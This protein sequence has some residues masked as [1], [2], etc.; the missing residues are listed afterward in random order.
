MKI[1]A[2]GQ[3]HVLIVGDYRTGT[4]PA[5][6]TKEYIRCL[7]PDAFCLK[8]ASR[9]GRALELIVKIPFASVVLCSGYSAQNIL[10][11]KWA[12]FW[13]KKCVYL[14][15]GS[16]EHENRINHCEDESM[17]RIEAETLRLSDRIYAVSGRFADWLKE[18][19]PEYQEKIGVQRNGVDKSL[20]FSED[21][22]G[23]RGSDGSGPYKRDLNRLLSIGGGMPR[24][25]ILRI[26]EAVELLRK[27]EGLAELKLTVI[28]DQGA[29]SEKIDRYEFVEDLGLVDPKKARELLS[30]AGLFIQNSCFETFGLA[31]M[32]ALVAGCDILVSREVGALELFDTEGLSGYIIEDHE[33]VRELS[34]KIRRALGSGNRAAFQKAFIGEKASWEMR[35]KEL[36]SKLKSL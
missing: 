22:R 32:E 13:K 10:A 34:Q 6:V 30:E 19:Y 33:D 15:H 24:K 14:M 29:D 28:G 23:D 16:V 2:P 8:T 25:R 35:A 11:A 9:A 1:L 20:S 5:N 17:T 4:G 31:P 36:L 3:I 26:C 12:H 21:V 18:R 27:E 7:G